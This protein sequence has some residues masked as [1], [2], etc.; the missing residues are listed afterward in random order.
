MLVYGV[1]CFISRFFSV[2]CDERVRA[3]MWLAP[4]R[5]QVPI[6][7]PWWKIY[8]E[9]EFAHIC[10]TSY[11]RAC[12][13]CKWPSLLWRIQRVPGMGSHAYV[14]A[15]GGQI[16]PFATARKFPQ[17]RCIAYICLHVHKHEAAHGDWMYKVQDT[18]N[19]QATRHPCLKRAFARYDP[20][21]RG[22]MQSGTVKTCTHP[23]KVKGM[24]R[25][26]VMEKKRASWCF[27]VGRM[28]SI[29]IR[30]A[31]EGGATDGSNH[32][33]LG[34]ALVILV[35]LLEGKWE[36]KNPTIRTPLQL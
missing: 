29:A 15:G 36:W 19:L 13:S 20:D 9:G 24:K 27:E 12:P 34:K 1:A 16:S 11:C 25:W 30:E 3:I 8:W 18:R 6:Y 32:W 31:I 14:G 28:I 4:F 33:G 35:F 2:W 23:R 21:S 7:V 22:S 26:Q 17:G 5:D 10:E